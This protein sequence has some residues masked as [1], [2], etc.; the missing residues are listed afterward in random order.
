MLTILTTVAGQ[1]PVCLLVNKKGF[2]KWIWFG[3]FA[4]FGN[5]FVCDLARE[6][7]GR[8]VT[9][10]AGSSLKGRTTSIL[11]DGMP[12]GP[13]PAGRPSDPPAEVPP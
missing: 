13:P 10:S 7:R 1:F 2:S 8:E 5:V 11:D 3:P 6:N 4:T 9:H 12:P